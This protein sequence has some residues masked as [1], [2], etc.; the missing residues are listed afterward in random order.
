[1]LLFSSPCSKQG[2]RSIPHT[3]S[4]YFVL[5]ILLQLPFSIE[6]SQSCSASVQSS[7]WS[8]LC[9]FPPPPSPVLQNP[10]FWS[11]SYAFT[12]DAQSH[13]LYAPDVLSLILLKRIICQDAAPIPSPK[14]PS[15]PAGSSSIL[16]CILYPLLAERLP[17]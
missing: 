9:L 5:Q 13:P 3:A 4:G 7:P 8:R 10:F 15:S 6:Q 17:H 14:P 2:D 16:S 11:G 12:C 1:M